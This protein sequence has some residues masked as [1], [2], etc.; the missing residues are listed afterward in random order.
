MNYSYEYDYG[1][2]NGVGLAVLFGILFFFLIIF[3]ILA[4]VLNKSMAD[5]A[6]INGRINQTI[7]GLP[8]EKVALINSLYINAKK[9]LGT[10]LLLALLLGS[11]GAHKIYLGRKTAAILFLLFSLTGIPAIISLFDAINMP[12]TIAEYNQSIIDS[13]T[14]QLVER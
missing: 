8:E 12:R 3:I 5:A 11:I 4:I 2:N 6:Q 7:A 13:V 9:E 10:A 14:A 1:V